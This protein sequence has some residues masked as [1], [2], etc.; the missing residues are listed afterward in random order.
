MILIG[1]K[2]QPSVPNLDKVLKSI[3]TKREPDPL[4]F[5]QFATIP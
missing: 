4:P 2:F 1:P 5:D 3:Q